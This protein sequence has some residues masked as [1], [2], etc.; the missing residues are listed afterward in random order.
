MVLLGEMSRNEQKKRV[1]RLMAQIGANHVSCGRFAVGE[2]WLNRAERALKGVRGVSRERGLIAWGRA[3]LYRWKGWLGRA[4]QQAQ[5]ACNY[6]A[7]IDDP[8]W[9]A[10]IRAITADIALDIAAMYVVGSAERRAYL[11]LAIVYGKEAPIDSH[12]EEDPGGESLGDLMQ[13]RW[14]RLGGDQTDLSGPINLIAAE[15]EQ[16]DDPSLVCGAYLVLAEGQEEAQRYDDARDAFRAAIMWAKRS[17]IRAYL[18][19]ARQRLAAFNR[20][21]ERRKQ[22]PEA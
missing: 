11:K 13:L 15:A 2:R 18:L 14:L 7:D 20:R 22:Q 12:M 6:F 5:R 17:P 1:A 4:L 10:R 9:Y 16:A 8:E 21:M 19:W 3:N